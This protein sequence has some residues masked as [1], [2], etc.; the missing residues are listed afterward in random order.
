MRY[1]AYDKCLRNRTRKYNWKDLRSAA[2]RSL[3]SQFSDAIGKTQ[4]F[5]DMKAL[6]GPPWNAPIISEKS[7][8]RYTDPAYSI[9]NQPLN[10]SEAEQIKSAILVL[11]RFKGLPQF[12]W[13]HEIVPKIEK[14]FGLESQENEIIGFDQNLDLKGL[15]HFN[16][17]FNA[18]SNKQV[19]E[20]NY[21]S[22]KSKDP[23]SINLHPYYLKQ[24]NNRWFLFGFNP[25]YSD[26][27]NLPLDRI[28]SIE[29]IITEKFIDNTTY[30]F[31]E[32]FDDIIGVTKFNNVDNQ[33]VKLW[34]A[35]MQ[36][37]YIDTKPLHGTQ[38]LYWQ[39][40]GSAHVTIE[41]IP[42]VELEH[43][44]LRFGESCKVLEPTSL[45]ENIKTKISLSL[46]NYTS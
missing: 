37:Q 18:I 24:Y 44:I 21:Q 39:D 14:E 38:K 2:N 9:V 4:F 31:E 32:Y 27:N 42:N 30:D 17:L 23:V 12:E 29:P 28:K 26:L 43:L 41:V 3:D 33:K 5:K 19:L 16:D 10:E 11:G 20:I 25:L 46:S 45:E 7:Y 8:Y 1:L 36:A 15:E 6:K 13:I 34:F 22:F 35:P 40:D